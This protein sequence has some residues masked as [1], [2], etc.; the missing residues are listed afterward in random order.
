VGVGVDDDL[1]AVFFGAA[2][3]EVVEVGAGGAGVVF[4]GD[5]EFGGAGEDLSM[6]IGVGLAAEDLAA[7][8]MAEDADVRVFERAED[9]GGHL[10][11]GLVEVGVDAGDDDVHL[12]EGGVVE[13]E[14]AVGEDVDLDAGKDADAAV[15]PSKLGVDFADALD[16]GQR[17]RVVQA[18]GH[19]E[20]LGVVGDGDVASRPRAMAASAICGWCRGRRWRRCACAGRRGCRRVMS[21]GSVWKLAAASISPQF[22]R[23]SGGM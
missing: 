23:S 3:V 8:G 15:L 11:D 17:A 22:S 9:A 5:A 16:V 19:G 21:C 1:A 18:V 12:G 6:S 4:D 14:R 10:F 2:E 7:G 20:V 13:V